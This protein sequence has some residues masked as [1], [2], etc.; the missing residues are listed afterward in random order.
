M[1]IL[2]GCIHGKTD[3]LHKTKTPSTEIYFIQNPVY[4]RQ[5]Q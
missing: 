5:E 1:D 3:I 2:Q 4:K